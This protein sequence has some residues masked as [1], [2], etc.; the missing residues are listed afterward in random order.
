MPCFHERGFDGSVF[1]VWAKRV[2]SYLSCTSSFKS[3]WCVNVVIF[4][5]T[6]EVTRKKDTFSTF[7][8]RQ[9]DSQAPPGV[10]SQ[11][12]YAH[13]SFWM[14]AQRSWNHELHEGACRK[15]V[16]IIITDLT[17][18]IQVLF[19][20][21]KMWSSQ[22]NL[23]KKFLL[24]RPGGGSWAADFSLQRQ[25]KIATPCRSP[26]TVPVFKHSA[27]CLKRCLHLPS[28]W[29]LLH[30]F[31]IL[32][33]ST[34]SS[35]RGRVKNRACVG[36]HE[37]AVS[38]SAGEMWRCSSGPPAQK[39]RPATWKQSGGACLGCCLRSFTRRVTYEPLCPVRAGKSNHSTP[40]SSQNREN[41]AVMMQSSGI[42]WQTSDAL[43]PSEQAK[44]AAVIFF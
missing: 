18:I 44:G 20:E 24:L 14:N 10:L 34:L 32:L 3:I 40:T 7:C 15:W 23:T 28:A 13:N 33:F 2:P 6:L 38:Q 36:V 27:V 17:V 30:H 21:N 37:D 43:G 9:K 1:T 11:M 8:V 42:T 4:A 22:C 12:M 19:R 41:A 16:T 29:R 5:L 25:R 31:Q 26:F 35:L 39:R